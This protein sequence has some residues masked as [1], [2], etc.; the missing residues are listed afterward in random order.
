MRSGP[1]LRYGRG[2]LCKRGETGKEN[3]RKGESKTARQGLRES[4]APSRATPHPLR[5]ITLSDAQLDLH[6]RHFL[7]NGVTGC[8]IV[9]QEILTTSKSSIG[10]GPLGP[11]TAPLRFR[12]REKDE[13]ML[14]YAKPG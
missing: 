5:T 6:S 13:V 11:T 3:L 7:Y 1:I 8:L 14:G 4:H 12:H 10:V 2:L 9:I